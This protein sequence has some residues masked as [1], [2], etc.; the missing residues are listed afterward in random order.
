MLDAA[1]ADIRPGMSPEQLDSLAT[2]ARHFP[3]GALG[4]RYALALALNGRVD[5]ALVQLRTMRATYG[6]GYFRTLVD[7]LEDR[8][9]RFPELRELLRRL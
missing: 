1:H 4:Y 6:E 9:L 8:A 3:Y 2:V 5:A 7:D